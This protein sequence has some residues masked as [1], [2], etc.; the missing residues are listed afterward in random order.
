[1]SEG[2]ILLHIDAT[3]CIPTAWVVGL[4]YLK[5]LLQ[6]KYSAVFMCS[7]F[8]IETSLLNCV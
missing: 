2:M 1:M 4:V 5:D 6:F 7:D 3:V 8:F